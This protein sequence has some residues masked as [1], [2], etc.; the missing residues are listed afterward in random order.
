MSEKFEGGVPPQEHK[1]ENKFASL[2]LQNYQ[3]IGDVLAAN[4]EFNNLNDAKDLIK[5]WDQHKRGQLTGTQQEQLRAF[6]A[7]YPKPEEMV[8]YGEYRLYKDQAQIDE[9]SEKRYRYI[10]TIENPEDVVA[11]YSFLEHS[12]IDAWH[13][14]IY[15]N[16]DDPR[17]I[18]LDSGE[19]YTELR[20]YM[21]SYTQGQTYPLLRRLKDLG[22]KADPALIGAIESGKLNFS[23]TIIELISDRDFLRRKLSE[24]FDPEKIRSDQQWYGNF[25]HTLA[26][27]IRRL[28][29]VGYEF[30][31]DELHRMSDVLQAQRR[32]DTGAFSELIAL[33]QDKDYLRAVLAKFSTL[34]QT[35][36]AEY[37][38]ETGE[39]SFPVSIEPELL[40]EGKEFEDFASYWGPFGS[41]PCEIIKKLDRQDQVKMLGDKSYRYE[42]RLFSLS[43]LD[44][45]K[46]VSDEVII[47]LLS[48]PYDYDDDRDQDYDYGQSAMRVAVIAGGLLNKKRAV[49][50][51]LSEEAQDSGVK[52]AAE[53]RLGQLQ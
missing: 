53:E 10:E 3:F 50:E 38:E 12:N 44:D 37:H 6:E 22:E 41:I 14:P 16:V 43:Q 7:I 8:E 51:R 11:L 34:D 35:K 1:V 40:P 31:E 4:P 25:E 42:T 19:S 15:R 27:T 29:E 28:A 33:I 9:F 23:T 46:G 45:L 13:A 26:A 5:A 49:L 20:S 39:N 24:Q 18:K 36:F 48:A 52:S 21:R 32:V 2:Q 17:R 30:D 47:E